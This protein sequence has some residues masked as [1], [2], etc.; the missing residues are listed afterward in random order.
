MTP[1][2]YFILFLVLVIN[3]LALRLA[4]A[5]SPCFDAFRGSQLHQHGGMPGMHMPED[6]TKSHQG[7]D[8]EV[9]FRLIHTEKRTLSKD[10][11]IKVEAGSSRALSVAGRKNTLLL[12]D[13]LVVVHSGPPD[14]MLS[15]RIQGIRN[16][17]L[18]MLPGATVRLLFVNMD[19]DMNHD[20]RFGKKAQSGT[21]NSIGTSRLAPTETEKYAAEEITITAQEAGKFLYYCSVSNH[22]A[23]GMQGIILVGDTTALFDSLHSG[24]ADT[25][26]Q[27]DGMHHDM[28]SMGDMKMGNEPMSHG[29]MEMSGM[30]H[31]GMDHMHMMH[32]GLLLTVPMQQ[33]GSGTSWMPRS[34]PMYMWMKDL[35]DWMMMIH[36][37]VMPRFDNQGGPRGD[38]KFDAPN[39]EMLMLHHPVGSD[40]RFSVLTMFSLDPV[41]EGGVGYPLLFQTGETWH[42]KKLV[43]RQHPHDLFAELALAYSQRFTDNLAGLVYFGYPG[44]PALGPPTFMHRSSAMSTPDAP[45]S[46]HWMDATHITFGVATASL[47]WN[48]W[49]LEGSYF[50]GR[51]PDENR[52]DFDK[53]QLNSYS[54]RLTYNPMDDLSFQVSNGFIKDP[55]GDS[56]DLVRTTASAIYTKNWGDGNWWSST[57][58]WGENHEVNAERLQS[59]LIESEYRF[60]GWAPYLRAEYVEKSNHELDLPGNPDTYYPLKQFTLGLTRNVLNITDF[61]IE[62][63][64]QGA[65]YFVPEQLKAIYSE[66]PISYEVFLSIHPALWK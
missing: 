23:N 18:L 58:A 9:P 2:K 5:D 4:H 13:R 39:M 20:L 32:N 51:E 1:C 36:G 47:S 52:D 43:D 46:H 15:Y 42:D 11:L 50:N 22:A 3:V 62:F 66:H 21:S 6:T 34:T 7:A 49:K 14:D 53:L 40:G 37:D 41:T 59:F 54:G 30:D 10:D 35:A 38:K 33:E 63:G 17:V 65:Y 61:E 31:M 55:E 48:Q 44:E 57:I 45:I 29:Q 27:I 16:P 19:D 56:I 24:M 64:V 60:S 25:A 26:M 12:S 8:Q 28:S